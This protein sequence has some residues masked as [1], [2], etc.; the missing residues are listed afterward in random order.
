MRRWLVVAA[1]VLAAAAV[2]TFAPEA[3]DVPQDE[4]P[5]PSVDVPTE[6]EAPQDVEALTGALQDGQAL[7]AQW[8]A[9]RDQLLAEQQRTEEEL[10]ALREL[11]ADL[12]DDRQIRWMLIGGGLVLV[13]LVLGVLIKSRPQ[14]RDAWQ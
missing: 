14:R 7:T 8:H 10:A 4:T 11:N 5:V 12:E 1:L 13:G 2:P 3:E 6:I 9:E